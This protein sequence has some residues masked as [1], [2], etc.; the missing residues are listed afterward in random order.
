MTGIFEGWLGMFLVQVSTDGCAHRHA[1]KEI[2]SYIL[3]K[4]GKYRKKT[5]FLTGIFEA[6]C[7][8][9]L[10]QVSK[11][12]YVGVLIDTHPK[13]S[14]RIFRKKWENIGKNRYFEWEI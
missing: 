14:D 13:K 10:A 5:D 1:P 11:D 4:M 2:G 7:G 12:G 3:K 8:I 6:W 9:F